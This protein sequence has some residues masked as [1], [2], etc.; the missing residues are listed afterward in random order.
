MHVIGKDPPE[1]EKKNVVGQPSISDKPHLLTY[2]QI[3]Y[4]HK[5]LE[6][7]PA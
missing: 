3:I 1:G 2:L 5:A 6:E 4:S 7:I